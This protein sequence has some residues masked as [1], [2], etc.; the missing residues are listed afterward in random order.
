MS[1]EHYLR[2]PYTEIDG[3]FCYF[4]YLGHL[5][6]LSTPETDLIPQGKSEGDLYRDSNLRILTTDQ[7]SVISGGVEAVSEEVIIELPSTLE[8]RKTQAILREVLEESGL[9]LDSQKLNILPDSTTKTIQSR[10]GKGIYL[11]R[12]TG[13][14]YELNQTEFRQLLT[15]LRERNRNAI[16]GTVAEIFSQ[17]AALELRPFAHSALQLLEPVESEIE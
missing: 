12:G 8:E 7:F 10:N 16:I 17:E 15:Y 11:I 3:V 14:S 5:I 13:F 1:L 4:W 9:V 2:Q 6:L